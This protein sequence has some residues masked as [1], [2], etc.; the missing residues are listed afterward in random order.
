MPAEVRSDSGSG[1]AIIYGFAAFQQCLQPAQKPRPS[2]VAACQFGMGGKSGVTNSNQ[3][4]LFCRF[5]LPANRGLHIARPA[6]NP[7]M[8]EQARRI[9]FQ[10][11]ASRFKCAAVGAHSG[12]APLPP[13][14]QIVLKLRAAIDA[15][16][17]PPAQ[18][19]AGI[20]QRLKYALWRRTDRDLADNGIRIGSNS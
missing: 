20:D 9:D 14:A 7:R 8:D 1:L 5:Q 2:A 6:G 19:L 16:M 12:F 3:R 4:A 15:R 13:G 10:I 11:F 18:H 17:P